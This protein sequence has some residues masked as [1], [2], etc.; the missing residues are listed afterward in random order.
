MSRKISNRAEAP[1]KVPRASPTCRAP[2]ESSRRRLQWPRG[3][4]NADWLVAGS[5]AAHCGNSR[6]KGQRYRNVLWRIRRKRL[7]QFLRS[8]V[9]VF[10]GGFAVDVFEERIVVR[11]LADDVFFA[12][13]VAEIVELTAFAA[14]RKFR[15]R[16]GVRRLLADGAAEFH[17]VKNT[18]KCGAMRIGR[19]GKTCT[20][21]RAPAK[22]YFYRRR[23]V[24]GTGEVF[25]GR[26]GC[27]SDRGLDA[28]RLLGR[29]A[30]KDG[31]NSFAGGQT[32]R[33]GAQE[34]ARSLED[35]PTAA[36]FGVP[37][38]ALLVVHSVESEPQKSQVAR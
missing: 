26:C 19:C 9:F 32:S 27:N 28:P 20:A 10:V 25:L 17:A 38:D 37:N 8:S 14:E 2:S 33:H 1:T 18:A 15:V 24:A 21:C 34:K 22:S 16:V 35:W 4:Q 12:G 30:C 13:P 29:I 3:A 11:R 36:D 23:G 5:V 6:R 7:G 31:C